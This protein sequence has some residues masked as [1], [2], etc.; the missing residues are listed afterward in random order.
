V[1]V[2]WRKGSSE[3]TGWLALDHHH[4]I[5]PTHLLRVSL[6]PPLTCRALHLHTKAGNRLPLAPSLSLV[7]YPS[8]PPPFSR[9][10]PSLTD[11]VRHRL[12]KDQHR[13]RL[14][15]LFVPLRTYSEHGSSCARSF[16][17][18]SFV[19]SRSQYDEDTLDDSE[20]YDADPRDANA[21]AE[22]AKGVQGEVRQVLGR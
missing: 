7:P 13:V 15:N 1:T 11:H 14:L 12:P 21:A 17:F 8:L 6:H 19:F 4:L 9:L 2:G 3:P 16:P 18:H 20:L 10:L 22:Y 5:R